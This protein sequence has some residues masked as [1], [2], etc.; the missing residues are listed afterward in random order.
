MYSIMNFF[1]SHVQ[2]YFTLVDLHANCDL[3][4]THVT[5]VIQ[6]QSDPRVWL[7][8]KTCP[9]WSPHLC[10]CTCRSRRVNVTGE[11]KIS[12]IKNRLSLSRNGWY[13]QVVYVGWVQLA[14]RLMSGSVL[15]AVSWMECMNFWQKKKK[16]HWKCN[17]DLR[18]WTKGSSWNTHTHTCVRTET[19]LWRTL[20]LRVV[21]LQYSRSACTVL[22]VLKLLKRGF[23]FSEELKLL[24]ISIS[25]KLCFHVWVI[26]YSRVFI[27]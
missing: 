12:G 8:T 18:I 23:F 2:D 3:T 17:I 13:L 20:L 14:D 1:F 7:E 6:F 24:S 26:L 21:S 5:F 19:W 27:K 9:W 11:D 16:R 15:G 22:T 25:F 4:Y 10:S